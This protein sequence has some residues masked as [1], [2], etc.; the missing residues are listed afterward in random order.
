MIRTMLEQIKYEFSQLSNPG[1]ARAL[2]T[3]KP[4]RLFCGVVLIT[5]LFIPFGA[6]H[7]RSEP[8]IIGSLW[9]YYLPIGYIGLLSGLFVI[10]SSRIPFVKGLRFGSVMIIIGFLLILSFLFSP[11]DYFI[12]L[13]NRTSF[14]GFQIDIDYPI[15]NSVIGG[16]ALLSITAGLVLRTKRN[17]SNLS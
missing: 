4:L 9:G 1:R 5:L 16:L 3:L 12:N 6:Y 10:F 11:K 15:G 2:I 8:F 14:S 13:L 7:S 17:H